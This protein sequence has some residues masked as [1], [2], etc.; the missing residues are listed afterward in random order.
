MARGVNKVILVGN[1]GQDPV[2]RFTPGGDAIANISLATSERWKDKQGEQQERTEWHRIVVIGKPAEIAQQYVR[3]GSKLYIEGKLQTRKWQDNNGQ[4]RY[5][6][7]V[8][9][10]GFNGQMQIL[11]KLSDQ[12]NQQYQAHQQNPASNVGQ[13]NQVQQNQYNSSSQPQQPAQPTGGYDD[14]D[15]SVPF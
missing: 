1:V 15:N 10:S 5:I 7:E 2:V 3:K 12:G 11:D 9:I 13:N 14:F 6:T 4:D 8:L